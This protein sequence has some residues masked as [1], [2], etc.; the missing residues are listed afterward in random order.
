MLDYF[1]LIVGSSTGGI[2][3]LALGLEIPAPKIVAFYTEHGPAIFKG[4]APKKVRIDRAALADAVNKVF[5]KS[6]RLRDSKALLAIPA[7]HSKKHKP[8]TFKTRHREELTRDENVTALEVVLSTTAVPFVL[9]EYRVDKE[10]LLDGGMWASNPVAFAVVEAANL[11]WWP[12]EDVRIL[13]LGCTRSRIDVDWNAWAPK[14][15]RQRHQLIDAFLAIQSAAAVTMAKNL[16]DD[17]HRILRIDP[18][19]KKPCGLGDVSQIETLRE[20][21]AVFAKR[22][23]SRIEERFFSGEHRRPSQL[24]A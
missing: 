5:G 17:N 24:F 1:D 19:L 11:K 10:A 18:F 13:S 12:G 20:A 2:I 9:P 4:S 21:G 3:A 7:T 8:H 16:L 22:K 15:F 14:R 23:L 6:R